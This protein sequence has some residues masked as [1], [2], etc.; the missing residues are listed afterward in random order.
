MLQEN[1][2]EAV[3][4]TDSMHRMVREF[5]REIKRVGAR[6]VLY[7]TWNP[8]AC[9]R[10]PPP[11]N[12]TVARIGR[13][14]GFRSRGLGRDPVYHLWRGTRACR[15]GEPLLPLD[16]WLEAYVSIAG[17]IDARVAPV[18]IAWDLARKENLSQPLYRRGGN[19]PTRLGAYLA[20][21]VF[22]ATIC[23]TSPNRLFLFERDGTERRTIHIDESD[24]RLVQRISW[25]AVQEQD[26]LASR[27]LSPETAEGWFALAMVYETE[28]KVPQ[29]L[30]AW[31]AYLDQKGSRTAIARRHMADCRSRL[32]AQEDE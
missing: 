26:D 7:M 1:S 31:E 3:L 18:G 22:Y 4:H 14:I 25:Q 17:E 9:L 20:V 27:R 5:D 12:P 2:F 10:F 15:R 11:G 28:G 21:C 29:A 19:H 16:P 24:A 6:T 32:L 13:L 30:D 23:D 8:E